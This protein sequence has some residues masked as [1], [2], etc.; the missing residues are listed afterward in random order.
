MALTIWRDDALA[1]LGC[2]LDTDLDEF[3]AK[4]AERTAAKGPT[5]MHE[6]WLKVAGAVQEDFMISSVEEMFSAVSA[7]QIECIL[8][9][10]GGKATW[11]VM[12]E[13]AAGMRFPSAAPPS[14]QLLSAVKSESGLQG[15]QPPTFA[16]RGTVDLLGD[17]DADGMDG[18]VLPEYVLSAHVEC[19]DPLQQ[20][21]PQNDITLVLD[22]YTHYMIT[23]HG[24]PA[25]DKKMRL[26][27]AKQMKNRYPRLCTY[28]KTLGCQRSWLAML[29]ERKR[30]FSRK[31]AL[32]VRLL[33]ARRS[34]RRS[35]P[36]PLASIAG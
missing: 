20:E 33:L 3:W 10:S 31:A 28:G 34:A 18:E 23:A 14:A 11:R 15:K 6:I 24:Q 30:N 36:V 29:T 22:A 13:F 8:T 5:N 35:A 4:I 1:T 25:C 21:L 27:H 7:T 32:K 12:I 26:H 9:R 17:E 16:I 19:E 2:K